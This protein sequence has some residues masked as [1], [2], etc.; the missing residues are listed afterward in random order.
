MS[1]SP[2]QRYGPSEIQLFFSVPLR[3]LRR[4]FSHG[5]DLVNSSDRLFDGDSN[6]A[7]VYSKVKLSS[8]KERMRW[9]EPEGQDRH[10]RCGIGLNSV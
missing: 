4:K 9:D 1:H 10:F 8:F 3:R 2:C 6:P 5:R 7:S